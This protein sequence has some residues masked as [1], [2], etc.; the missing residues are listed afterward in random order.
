M[1]EPILS[2][3]ARGIHVAPIRHH[4][5]ACAFHLMAM[6]EEVAPAAILVEGP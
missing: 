1:A 4:S 5:P 2:D 6:I 3:D